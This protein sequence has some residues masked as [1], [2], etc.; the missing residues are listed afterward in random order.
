MIDLEAEN[1][2]D[3]PDSALFLEAH[4]VW[5]LLFFNVLYVISIILFIRLDQKLNFG[6]IEHAKLEDIKYHKCLERVSRE[7][8]DVISSVAK[9]TAGSKAQVLRVRV[10][11]FL[12]MLVLVAT[13]ISFG[14]ITATRG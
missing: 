8:Q 6:N 7:G 9:G 12:C 5:I 14:V 10:Y 2:P 4:V 11:M 3:R 13:W 1:E